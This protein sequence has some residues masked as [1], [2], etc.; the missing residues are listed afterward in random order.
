MTLMTYVH[1]FEIGKDNY[2]LKK[3]YTSYC[4]TSYN[5]ESVNI[6]MNNHTASFIK[7]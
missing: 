4:S 2:I 6:I 3:M 5:N 7:N 1:N